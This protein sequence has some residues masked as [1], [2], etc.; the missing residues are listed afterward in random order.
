MGPALVEA[1]KEYLEGQY[2]A[3]S[4][5]T[6]VDLFSVPLTVDPDSATLA[7]WANFS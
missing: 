2:Q 5:L 1:Y 7:E 6:E 3:S 4:D